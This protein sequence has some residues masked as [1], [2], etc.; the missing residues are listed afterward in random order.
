ML[1]Y[2]E[3]IWKQAIGKRI[4]HQDVR[5]C[6]EMR[7]ARVLSPVALQGASIV[8][9]AEFSAQLLE[10]HPVALLPLMPDLARQMALQ[11]GGDAIVVEE[12]VIPIEQADDLT[13][14]HKGIPRWRRL[15][16][17]KT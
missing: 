1:E 17:L 11:V 6:E 7:I 15:P 4:V 12:P 2:V 3:R 9:V 8:G 13:A 16:N 5:N 14:H 10:N